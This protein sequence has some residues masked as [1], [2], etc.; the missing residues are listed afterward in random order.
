[1][2]NND[3]KLLKH[4]RYFRHIVKFSLY[5]E[6]YKFTNKNSVKINFND[7]D[8][9]FYVNS[10]SQIISDSEGS[11]YEFWLNNQKNAKNGQIYD[12][13]LAQNLSKYTTEYLSQ[14]Y[15]SLK[16]LACIYE[17]L[18]TRQLNTQDKLLNLLVKK[19]ENYLILNDVLLFPYVYLSKKYKD[20]KF[21][22]P[23]DIPISLNFT[24]YNTNFKVYMVISDLPEINPYNLLINNKDADLSSELVILE[25]VT[26]QKFLDNNSYHTIFENGNLKNFKAWNE[27]ITYIKRSSDHP[28]RQEEHVRKL[29]HSIIYKP[30]DT[31]DILF[32]AYNSV[33][34]YVQTEKISS[35]GLL[36]PFLNESFNNSETSISPK[37]A[38]FDELKTSLLT[39]KMPSLSGQMKFNQNGSLFGLNL[40]QRVFIHCLKNK[41]TP[42]EA[43]NGPPGTGKTTTLQ[44]LVASLYVDSIVNSNET[45]QP[46]TI[47]GVS[48][49]NQAKN[50]IID[51]FRLNQI[52]TP[53]LCETF[54]IFGQRW[55]PDDLD[56]GIIV[57]NVDTIN[58]KLLDKTIESILTQEWLIK[59][60]KYYLQQWRKIDLNNLH[61]I[62]SQV[63]ILNVN[64][65][66]IN[67]IQTD[68]E[69]IKDIKTQIFNL[70]DFIYN[71]YIKDSE[72]FKQKVI[73]HA[74]DI[75]K[76]R[77]AIDALVSDRQE[78][79]NEVD[80]LENE[81]KKYQSIDNGIHALTKDWLDY[82]KNL[83]FI[84]KLFK[85]M[86]NEL[87][88]K[89]KFESLLRQYS[90]DTI[91]NFHP[92]SYKI[93]DIDQFLT[94]NHY[95]TATKNLIG[96]NTAK[97]KALRDKY[98]TLES[99]INLKLDQLN[100]LKNFQNDM[101]SKFQANIHLNSVTALIKKDCLSIEE[102]ETIYNQVSFLIDNYL[103]TLLFH[104]TMRFYEGQFL[105]KAQKLFLNN[106]DFNKEKSN[107][108]KTQ[109]G[110]SAK[111]QLMSHIFPCFVSTA[112]SIYKN[113][114]Y[115][116]KDNSIPLSDFIDYLL[117]DEAGQVSPEVG[118]LAFIHAKKA[119][120]VGDTYQLEPVWS[121]PQARDYAL[122]KLYCDSSI[123][124][125]DF[126]SKPYNCHS[127]S[128]MTIAQNNSRQW[129][130]KDLEKGLYLL[131]HRR[132]P[133]EIIGFCNELMYK[134]KLKIVD[135][136][137]FY[138]IKDL[139]LDKQEPWHFIE[140]TGTCENINSSRLNRQEAKEIYN[141]FK[142][143]APIITAK[144]NLH[145][146]VAVLTPFR[147]QEK[148]IRA[149]LA[150]LNYS[151]IDKLII[152][153]VH[154]LQGAEKKII[155]FSLVYD[156]R[157]AGQE[158]FIDRNK[159]IT[160]VMVSR[161]K[162]S[163][164]I[165][166]NKN[167]FLNARP[168]SATSLLKNYLKID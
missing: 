93:A 136:S 41:A 121:V 147:E 17:I 73:N 92:E 52:Q 26:W 77:S 103:K 50:N 12:A 108:K 97:I 127:K 145:E 153:T 82:K 146:T 6:F 27:I 51:G 106:P 29:E 123:E 86:Q 151:D 13:F 4:L 80:L 120:I 117:I 119:V 109:N 60:S 10:S 139:S 83:S 32:K 149:E 11:F 162:Q 16:D 165:F 23:A 114:S 76:L 55:L 33:I 133:K 137:S 156:E 62:L 19:L 59:G 30:D 34:N 150:K 110:L 94:K 35:L 118:A 84:T 115:M 90:L 152:G 157:S 14:G 70:I 138:N 164:Y 39:E 54:G 47:F 56:Y 166:G 95:I 3:S 89:F 104:L 148:L 163:I 135:G 107:F 45:K 143:N 155:L 132:C 96:K 75:N 167:V 124:A 37:F 69:G 79:T 126:E 140:V 7:K 18:K 1:M 100:S 99:Q 21:I 64:S 67:A 141:W 66:W 160:N 112:H 43:L 101:I 71:N 142:V 85:F 9:N 158:L 5:K 25:E 87:E 111:Y 8:S 57:G 122:Y 20:D 74:D 31:I 128:V 15:F 168:N 159:N 116:N 44:S 91:E 2:T 63:A 98:N 131:E 28:I 65:S 36:L 125:N 113:L 102:K 161:A 88:M 130:F 48:A 68:L 78:L 58:F 49:T 24:K 53:I 134:N 129:P 154:K 22:A 72:S 144:H 40:E 42:I 38:N 81:V 61:K 105:E 46:P